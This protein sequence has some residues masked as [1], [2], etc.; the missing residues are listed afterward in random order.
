M[1]GLFYLASVRYL[2]QDAALRTIYNAGVSQQD[3]DQLRGAA[4]WSADQR[5]RIR[6]TLDAVVYSITDM[7][8]LPRVD[9][10]AEMVAAVVAMVISPANWATCAS[11]L[12][13]LRPARDVAEPEETVQIE[14]VSAA[15]M[16]VLVCMADASMR[17]L[18]EYAEFSSKLAG[19]FNAKEVR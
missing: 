1:N 15:R 11:W 18:S 3:F 10:P 2:A 17:G 8:Q 19:K 6:R 13:G 7:A 4:I 16:L 5:T 9:V 14:R 12:S